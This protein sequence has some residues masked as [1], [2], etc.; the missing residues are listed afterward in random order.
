MNILIKCRVKFVEVKLNKVGKAG[1]GLVVNKQG[2]IDSYSSTNCIIVS[3]RS[4]R[5]L[6]KA[7]S[8]INKSNKVELNL[9]IIFHAQM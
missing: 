3:C 4:S 8:L 2:F 6:T 9:Q 1:P 7:L 5:T